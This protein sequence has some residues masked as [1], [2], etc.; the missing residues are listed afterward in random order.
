LQSGDAQPWNALGRDCALPTWELG[1]RQLV[2]TAYFFETDDALAHRVDDY[3]LTPRDPAPCIRRRQVGDSL[4]LRQEPVLCRVPGRYALGH[5]NS[6]VS[7]VEEERDRFFQMFDRPLGPLR[8]RRGTTA[9]YNRRPYASSQRFL[10]AVPWTTLR[11]AG[12][13]SRERGSRPVRPMTGGPA[14]EKLQL[15]RRATAS[16]FQHPDHNLN[17]AP[18]SLGLGGREQLAAGLSLPVETEAAT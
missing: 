5:S 7:H 16:S 3:R 1:G 10:S 11:I 4:D 15:T 8:T 17:H 18:A 2:A 12:R 14:R 13:L 9:P 6:I